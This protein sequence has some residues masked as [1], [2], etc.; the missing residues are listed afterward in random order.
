PGGEGVHG[1]LAAREGALVTVERIVPTGVIRRHAGFVRL[2][3][4]Y[5]RAVA[6]APLGG[7]PG[8][9]AS[10]LAPEVPGYA[11]DYAFAR[12]QREAFATPAGADAWLHEWVD[13]AP[14]PA[15]YARRLGAERIAALRAGAEPEAWRGGLRGVSAGVPAP[16]PHTPPGRRAVR[17]RR[18][19]GGP[20]RGGSP[21]SRPP[22]PR[23]SRPA[24]P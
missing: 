11:E 4:A 12:A 1:A 15:D 18:R 9:M 7:H 20:A 16:G 5:V 14:T 2:P 6:E 13:G 22:R 8:G 17:G 21:A 24:A 23:R 19:R 3:A 10:P